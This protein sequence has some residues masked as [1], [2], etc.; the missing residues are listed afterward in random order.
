VAGKATAIVA[1]MMK[2]VGFRNG[3]L[4]SSMRCL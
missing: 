3:F 4:G 2:K 1:T